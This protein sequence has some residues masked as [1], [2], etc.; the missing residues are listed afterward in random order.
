M[1]SNAIFHI[2]ILIPVTMGK[3]WQLELELNDGNA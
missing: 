1:D 2:D 3:D